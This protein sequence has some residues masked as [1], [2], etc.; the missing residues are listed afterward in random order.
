MDLMN[1][2]GRLLDLRVPRIMGVLNITPDSFTDGG[3]YQTI[4]TCFRQTEK[5]LS[6]GAYIIDVGAMSSKPGNNIISPQD[7]W[8]RLEAILPKL[9]NYFPEVFFSIDTV[10]SQTAALAIEAGAHIIND[11]SGFNIDE[12]MPLLLAQKPV[13]YV[14]MH[15]QG[16]PQNMQQNPVYEDVVK[17]VIDYFV[18]KIAAL[19]RHNFF[20]IILDPG[21]GFGKTVTHN[22]ELLQKLSTITLLR[23][24]ILV[25]ISRKS[26]INRTLQIQWSE[27]LPANT[28][29]HLF[30]LMKGARILRA[31]EVLPAMQ[32]I[33]IAEEL[34]SLPA[35]ETLD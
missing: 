21:F 30:S 5:M 2:H 16:T 7:E 33:K 14:L 27:S 8:K 19:E 22:W 4:E 26:F 15:I 3:K 10:H 13:A 35:Y 28:A 34:Q 20:Q 31:H 29:I 9:I 6:A 18:Q 1:C 25:G 32:A 17:E 11:I 24:P 12:K 23:K